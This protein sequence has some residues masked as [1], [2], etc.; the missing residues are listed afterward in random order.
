MEIKWSKIFD[1]SVTG[2]QAP[3][4]LN[5]ADGVFAYCVDVMY[6]HHGFRRVI[7]PVGRDRV[8]VTG[9]EFALEQATQF[10]NKM[11]SR[12]QQHSKAR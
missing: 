6:R 10:F 2:V 3:Y 11:R 1:W 4:A 9:R 12:M 5:G 7:F 8:Y